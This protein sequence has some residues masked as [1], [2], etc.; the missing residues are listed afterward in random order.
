M[1]RWRQR[2]LCS[3][4]F[5]KASNTLQD[6]SE[7]PASVQ[8]LKKGTDWKSSVGCRPCCP[9]LLLWARLKD[10]VE[11]IAKYGWI[12]GLPQTM[13][14]QQLNMQIFSWTSQKWIHCPASTGGPVYCP[15]N[16][17]LMML[18]SGL[19]WREAAKN[20]GPW[21]QA[22]NQSCVMFCQITRAAC[23]VVQALLCNLQ[24]AMVYFVSHLPR[25]AK[26]IQGSPS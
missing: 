2:R 12:A 4:G 1:E 5:G 18:L 26:H 16:R 17:N 11:Q 23:S 8:H 9:L 20:K 14:S 24:E 25:P 7:T 15:R 3:A 21:P 6:L 19:E 13:S 22:Q 10:S